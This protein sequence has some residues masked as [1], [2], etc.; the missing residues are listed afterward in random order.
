MINYE[1]WYSTTLEH[2]NEYKKNELGISQDGIWKVIA[3]TRYDELSNTTAPTP[4]T[5]EP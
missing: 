1:K 4:H 3:E 2:L 5:T